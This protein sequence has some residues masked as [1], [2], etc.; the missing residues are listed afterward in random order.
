MRDIKVSVDTEGYVIAYEKFIANQFEN[1]ATRLVFDLPECYKNE[2]FK[3]YVVFRLSNDEI[4][5][6]KI[7]D[8]S[9]DCIIDRDITKVSG[10][11]LFQTITKKITGADDLADGVVMSSQPISGYV[12]E[13]SYKNQSILNANVD[14]NIKVYLDEFDALL[15]EIRSTDKRLST[16]I[17]GKSD[18]AEII[19]ARGM[20]TTLKKRLDTE[21]NNIE[22][23]ISNTKNELDNKI[24]KTISGSPLVANSVSGMVDTTKVYINITDGNWYYHDGTNWVSGGIYQ[25]MIIANK[26]INPSKTTFFDNTINEFNYN[27]IVKG[28]YLNRGIGN[29]LSNTI[30]FISGKM[31]L[32]KNAKYVS[33]KDIFSIVYYDMN[34]N[35]IYATT[36]TIY[37]NTPFTTYNDFEYAKFSAKIE[38]VDNFVIQK[39]NSITSNE[40]YSNPRLNKSIDIKIINDNIEYGEIDANKTNFVKKIENYINSNQLIKDKYWL[41]NNKTGNIT[42]NSGAFCYCLDDTIEL[43]PNNNYVFSSGILNSTYSFLSNGVICKSISEFMQ[44]GILTPTLEFN[45]LY[46]TFNSVSNK[47]IEDY[48]L[49]NNNSMPNYFI[50]FNKPVYVIDNLFMDTVSKIFYVGKNRDIKTL[51]KGIE[52]ATSY[53][54]SILYVDEGEYD[55]Y[56]EF[57]EEFFNNYTKKSAKGLVLKNNIHIIFSPKSKVIFEYAGDNEDVHKEFSPFNGSENGYTLENATIIA[58]NCRYCLHDER[59]GSLEFYKNY[60][61]NCNFNL[62]NSNNPDWNNPQT[63]GGGLGDN[64]VVIIED[65]ISNSWFTYHTNNNIGYKSSQSSLTIKNNYIERGSIII[66]SVY[67]I[68]TPTYVKICNNSFSQDCKVQESSALKTYIYNNEI[69]GN[70]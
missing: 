35:V 11:C 67:E 38:N 62:D 25:S 6:R 10:V 63:I 66:T 52:V 14:S 58:K 4:V 15:A 9:Y 12:K 48:M 68:S 46:A 16:I 2:D 55:L 36:D 13:S 39:G 8:T 64:G 34:D 47:D 42:Q 7:N 50:P 57:G 23:K 56:Q 45:K 3:N 32:E 24:N 26:T 70:L 30:Y 18:F 27:E 37:A 1:E 40:K 20:Y 69:R 19:D 49:I 5:I 51:K 53:N 43:I 41:Y 33:S 59:G 28:R 29:E 54:N 21:K 17:N 60:I 61:R 65:C 44:N 22:F 31:Y